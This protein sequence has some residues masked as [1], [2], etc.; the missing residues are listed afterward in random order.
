MSCCEAECSALQTPVQT[1]CALEVVSVNYCRIQTYLNFDIG[2][3]VLI[4]R[5]VSWRKWILHKVLLS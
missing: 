2:L 3:C 1:M 5:P 4:M